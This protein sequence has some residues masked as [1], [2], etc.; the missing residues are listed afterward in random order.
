MK[1]KVI[2]VL[3]AALAVF[4]LLTGC[5]NE[6]SVP[7]PSS[8]MSENEPKYIPYK[9]VL[10]NYEVQLPSDW[11]QSVDG[12]N[13][14][15]TESNTGSYIVVKREDYFPAINLYSQDYL[16]RSFQQDGTTLQSYAKE[17]GNV[18]KIIISYTT[19]NVPITEY[20]YIVWSYD[21]VYY[22]NYVAESKNSDTFLETYQTVYQSFKNIKEE[23]SITEGYACAYNEGYNMSLEYPI[24]WDYA[25]KGNGFTITN[26]STTSSITLETAQAIPNF[27]E[28]TQLDY[29]QILQSFAQGS[30]LTSFKNTG[31]TIY[32]SAY[33][34]QETQKYLIE[35]VLID[36]GSYT[37]IIT[38]VSPSSYSQ[39]DESTFSHML[40]SIKYYNEPSPPQTQVETQ[41]T[42]PEQTQAQPSSISTTTTSAKSSTTTAK[43][44]KKAVQT[45]T[46]K[47][48]VAKTTKATTTKKK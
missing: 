17:K 41:P 16:A 46:K 23:Q 45:T 22:I 9:T 7:A 21:A 20:K 47:G 43:T 1:T 14:C 38:Y 13:I 2:A 29:N 42:Q 15:V 27:S 3:L 10:G 11:V 44:T 32:A 8:E 37:L 26:T 39:M 4:P 30:S 19:N 18:L 33:Y 24:N 31:G 28:Y 34:A 35:N 36:N 12:N 6:D 40:D 48:T 25:A 5:N